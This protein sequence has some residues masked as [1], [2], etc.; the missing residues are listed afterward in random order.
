MIRL[1]TVLATVL[2]CSLLSEVQY[3]LVSCKSRRN[4]ELRF[5]T[6]LVMES[7]ISGAHNLYLRDQGRQAMQVLSA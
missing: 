7:L 5:Q 2:R 1:L 3:Q 4:P 6:E